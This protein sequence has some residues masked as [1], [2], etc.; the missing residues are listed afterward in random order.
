M[1]PVSF[2]QDNNGP[3]TTG[4]TVLCFSL[5]FVVPLVFRLWLLPSPHPHTLVVK[6][7]FFVVMRPMYICISLGYAVHPLAPP[8]PFSSFVLVAPVQCPKMLSKAS[9]FHPLFS[10]AKLLCLVDFPSSV[11]CIA[12]STSTWFSF[13]FF[14]CSLRLFF[15]I[16]S[17]PTLMFCV[18]FIPGESV[19]C[20]RR[21]H[22]CSRPV[23]YLASA[24]S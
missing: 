4:T 10:R 20:V 12:K 6:E 8:L 22:S 19:I 2:S 9:A 18:D 23:R 1:C 13:H 16:V 24:H 3:H 14:V 17:L 7:S 11:S 21:C 15:T 5:S